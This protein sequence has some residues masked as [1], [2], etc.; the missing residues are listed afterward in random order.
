ME[1]IEL[2]NYNKGTMTARGYKLIAEKYH[3]ATNLLHER[4]QF[5]NR[6]RQ[7][8]GMFN[9][10]K[11]LYTRSGL[12]RH[13]NGWPNATEDW[14]EDETKG[15]HEWKK[16][17][18]GP[19]KYLP[20]LEQI[21]EGVAVDGSTS[22]VAGQ[23]FIEAEEDFQEEPDVFE[24]PQESPMSSG[25]QKRASS[26]STTSTTGTSPVKKSKSLVI[27]MIREFFSDDDSCSTDDEEEETDDELSRDEDLVTMLLQQQ[28]Q[29]KRVQACFVLYGARRAT[30]ILLT[31]SKL[32]ASPGAFH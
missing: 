20:L 7:L 22:F 8:K 9:F 4:K 25:S 30:V 3:L 6:I 2:G 31:K 18:Y 32:K 24:H 29:Q 12:G 16:L 13:E 11:E 27:K 28:A 15:H 19:P 5:A 21:F 17:K 14:W 26:T 1:Q 23:D 10:I